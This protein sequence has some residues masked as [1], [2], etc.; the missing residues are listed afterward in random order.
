MK[1]SAQLAER[2]PSES[3]SFRPLLPQINAHGN[4][5]YDKHVQPLER[6]TDYRTHVSGVRA[7]DLK[8]TAGRSDTLCALS[9]PSSF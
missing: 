3:C 1:R 7:K 4:V 6:V 2:A 9:L 5:L 8:K